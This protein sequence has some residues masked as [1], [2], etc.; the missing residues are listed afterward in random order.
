[1][2]DKKVRCSGGRLCQEKACTHFIRTYPHSN[3]EEAIP[4]VHCCQAILP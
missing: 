3:G 2:K 1:M 4:D